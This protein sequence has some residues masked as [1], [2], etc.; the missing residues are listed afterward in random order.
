MWILPLLQ[1]RPV[2]TAIVGGVGFV[3]LNWA[4]SE[5]LLELAYIRSAITEGQWWRLLSGHFVH[6]TLYHAMM[7]AVGWVLVSAVLLYRQSLRLI[8]SVNLFLPVFISMGL[9]WFYQD[10][11]QYRGYSGVLYGLIAAGLLFEW[12]SNKGLHT[13]ALILASGKIAYEQ[14]PNYDIHYLVAE[15]GVPV[16]IEAHLL[17]FV[18]GLLFGSVILI[19]RWWRQRESLDQGVL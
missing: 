12:K 8:V 14:W 17:G 11:G 1:S 16:A 5:V 9:W 2:L 13:I 19:A 10:I 4:F 6:F 7:N 18:G 15:I 3:I